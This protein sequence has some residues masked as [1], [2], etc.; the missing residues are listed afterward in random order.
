MNLGDT[1]LRG[2]LQNIPHRVAIGLQGDGW[3]LRNT[4]IWAKTNPKPSSSKSN[5]CPTYEFIFHFVKGKDYFYNLTLAPLKDST[6]ASLPPR[7]RGIRKN[8][9]TESPYIPR[10]GK[11]MGDFWTEDVVRTAVVNQ[12]LTSN[13]NE[14]PAPFPEE[15]IT[16]PILQTSTEG[17]LILDL[18]M[19]SGTTGRVANDLN[20]RFVGYD[21]RAF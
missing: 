21:L 20:R 13:K 2:N 10:E 4:I 5:L 6:K 14:H 18:F 17:D 19:G 7:H 9:K 1:Y 16:L 3:I 15:I 11:N 8:G 12:R